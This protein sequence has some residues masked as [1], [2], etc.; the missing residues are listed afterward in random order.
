MREYDLNNEN[1]LKACGFTEDEYEKILRDILKV[2]GETKGRPSAEVV[3]IL[4]ERND[5]DIIRIAILAKVQDIIKELYTYHKNTNM[6][7]KERRRIKR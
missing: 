4:E 7:R 3:R 2:M 6:N 1:I 5:P